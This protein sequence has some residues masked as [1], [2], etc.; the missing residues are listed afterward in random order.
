MLVLAVGAMPARAQNTTTRV[1]VSNAG[2]EANAGSSGPVVSADGRFVVFASA[3]TN[4][5]PGDSNGRTD[6]FVRDRLSGQIERVSVTASGQQAIGG[7]STDPS[8]SSDGRF[9]AFSS[10]AINLV[11][12]DSNAQRDIFVRDRQAATT[13]RVSVTSSGSQAS[14]NSLVPFISADGRYVAFSSTAALVPEDTNDAVD[15][16]RH[17]RNTGSIV[18]VSVGAVSL[19]GTPTQ[20]N[21]DSF[22]TNISADGEIVVFLSRASNLLTT[23]INP[24]GG[25]RNNTEDVF[26]RSLVTRATRRVSIGTGGV[27]GNSFSFNGSVSDDGRFVVFYSNA[28]NLVPNGQPGLYLHDRDSGVTSAVRAGASSSADI[29]ANGRY[30][31]FLEIPPSELGYGV[32]AIDRVTSIR[33]R[34]SVASNG[35]PATGGS[36]C[37]L[38]ADAT[39]V[40]FDS[41]ASNLVP[42]D[43]NATTDVFVRTMFPT[44]ALEKT[45]LTFAAVTSG[46]AFIAQTAAQTL[47][48]T[49]NGVGTAT[50]TAVSNEPWLQISPPSGSGSGE[51]SIRVVPAAG[52]PT[53]G[54]VRGTIFVSVTGAVNVVPGIAVTLTLTPAGANAVP[55]GTVDTP[56]DNRTGVTGAIPFTGWALDDIEVIRVSVCRAAF[57]AEVPPA[58]PNCGG[59]AEIFIGF[60]VF[61]DGARPDV[62]AAFP[63]YPLATR[64]GWGIMILTNMLPNRGN[65]IY[66]F[67]MR[68]QDREGNWSILG[69]RTMTAANAS[70]TLPFGTIDTPLQGGTASGA[71][72]VNFGWALTPLPKTIPIDGSTIAV[73]IDGVT[74][75]NVNYNHARPDIQGLFPGLNNTDGAVGFHVIDTTA[76]ANG[77]HTIAWVVSDNLGATE[78]L[79]SRYF[80]VSNGV[81]TGDPAVTAMTSLAE[82]EAAPIDTTALIGRRG[83]D[84][85][86]PLGS[87]GAGPSGVTVIRSEEV[88]RVELQLG[89]GDYTGYLRTPAGL[90]PLPVGAHI[91][92]TT[93]TFTWAPGVGFVGRYDLVFVRSIDGRVAARR[94]VRILLHP[95]GRGAVGP[96]VVIDIPRTTS[97][98]ESRFMIGGWAIDLDAAD[99]TGV[100]TLH[101]WAFP[102]TGGTPIFLGATAYG[103]ARPDV[104]AVHG[105]RFKDSGFGLIAQGL[106]AGDY[107]LALF[108]WSTEAMGFVTPTTTRI[109][110]RPQ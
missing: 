80:T 45:T 3:A 85:E 62:T 30:V 70:A 19:L 65:G 64:G 100:T 60:A 4:L 13:T 12:A 76:L 14:G 50:W 66:R 1:S 28:T 7:H 74:V 36:A 68:A 88:S 29:S 27:E 108:A 107:D 106:P 97:I 73:L 17:D 55:F 18:R 9:V 91:D 48:L 38:S 16:F 99:G 71:A 81:P 23:P 92:R 101:A 51:L 109:T 78:G 54:T 47:R 24:G 63:A 56:P 25:D 8:I 22:V 82:V 15:V 32:F 53:S 95:K 57:G 110:V 59:A 44:V 89:V 58:D 33:T 87:F 94:D 67:T 6:I 83:W 11:A 84:P 46:G 49:Q 104:A 2:A 40:A 90:A 102:A 43:T 20:A 21:G 61:I 105:E 72:Y 86:A 79:G 98:V 26:V 75:G 77:L 52:L 69:T 103:G 37:S 5:V 39:V 35:D 31:C 41:A 10:D 93:K 34:V 42:G 96:Q